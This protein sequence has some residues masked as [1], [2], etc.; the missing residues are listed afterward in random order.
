M[1]QPSKEK[2]IYTEKVSEREITC[3]LILLR[4]AMSVIKT[5]LVIDHRAKER[6][7]DELT[8]ANLGNDVR[9]Y[10]RKMQEK[11]KAI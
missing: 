1:L 9:N 3:R 4:M 2:F 6:E 11:R 7:C 8:L 10:L 5:Q